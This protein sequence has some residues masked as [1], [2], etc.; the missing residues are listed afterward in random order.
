MLLD[1]AQQKFLFSIAQDRQ[2]KEAIKQQIMKTI[3]E[4]GLIFSNFYV[5]IKSLFF[6]DGSLL[7]IN[8]RR[9]RRFR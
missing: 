3:V 1:L 7:S 5:N 8:C 2:T 6:R 9:I 4:N